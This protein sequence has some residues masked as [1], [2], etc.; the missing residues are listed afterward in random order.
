[1]GNVQ[2]PKYSEEAV[3]EIKESEEILEGKLKDE[4]EDWNNIYDLPQ[5][6]MEPSEV[7][8][9]VSINVELTNTNSTLIDNRTS[10]AELYHFFLKER[11]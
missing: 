5:T 2:T 9:M 1:M 8:K 4:L 6:I 11:F 10:M 7:L 3:L